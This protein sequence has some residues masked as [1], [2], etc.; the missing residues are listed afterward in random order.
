MKKLV[1]LIK[2]YVSIV[3][4]ALL[5]LLYMSYFSYKGA[6]L[7]LGIIGFIVGILYIGLGVVEAFV[8]K[9]L[10]KSARAAL[11]VAEMCLFPLFMFVYILIM[12]INLKDNMVATGWVIAIYS[13]IA[14]LGFMGIYAMSKFVRNPMLVKMRVVVAVAF[15]LVLLLGILFDVTGA[16]TA[17]GDVGLVLL[18]M[19]ALFGYMMFLAL[20]QPEDPVME[21]P[22]QVEAPK[23]EQSEAPQEQWNPIVKQKAGD[24]KRWLLYAFFKKKN[25]RLSL[26][27]L[28]Q[29]K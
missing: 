29:H 2:P 25:P 4:G 15:G 5:V 23:E 20:I 13:L 16:P 14:S 3:L 9:K 11:D 12:M 18:I 7:A 22:K 17:L 1:D 24:V 21:E 10:D 28:I 26:W 8:A 27:V 19:Y 6:A